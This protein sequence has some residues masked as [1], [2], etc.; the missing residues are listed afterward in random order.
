MRGDKGISLRERGYVIPNEGSLSQ[1]SRTRTVVFDDVSRIFRNEEAEISCV[2]EDEGQ[3][4]CTAA[5][6]LEKSEHDWK[7]EVVQRAKQTRRTLRK[8][9]EVEA[10]DEGIKGEI[11]GMPSFVGSKEFAERNGVDISLYELEAKR[12]SKEGFNIQFVAKGQKCLGL[13]VGSK[14]TIV[15]EFA[16]IFHK[17]NENKWAIAVMGNSLNI[18]EDVL[19]QYGIDTSWRHSDVVERVERIRLNGEEVLFVCE[20]KIEFPSVAHYEMKNIFQ[21][22]AY[23]KRIDMLVKEHFR[24]AKMWNIAGEMLAVW[25]IFTAP[26][27]ALMAN[28]L[29]LTFYLEQS[30]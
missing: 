14:I 1:L 2:S 8:A 10:D 20:E 19:T 28:A 30:G 27:I 17:L 12:L 26:V 16:H 11:Q 18:N 21:S 4:L 23:A 7:D 9:F 24:V 15:P 22:I 25:S 13:L 3:V 6:L 29:S 5:S